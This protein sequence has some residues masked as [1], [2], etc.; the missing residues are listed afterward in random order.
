M[1]PPS[2][3]EGV[4]WWFNGN[5]V[6]TGMCSSSPSAFLHQDA[7]HSTIK[8]RLQ[9]YACIRLDLP[10]QICDKLP[11]EPTE[12]YLPLSV[13]G[14]LVGRYSLNFSVQGLLISIIMPLYIT[15]IYRAPP[16]LLRSV[17]GVGGWVG[18]TIVSTCPEHPKGWLKA[19][20]VILVLLN[21]NYCT[22][23]V[24]VH[25]WGWAWEVVI[26]VVVYTLIYTTLRGYT[27]IITS[28]ITSNSYILQAYYKKLEGKGSGWCS[29]QACCVDSSGEGQE[30]WAGD[31]S[32]GMMAWDHID[33]C[34]WPGEN[35]LQVP[36]RYWNINSTGKVNKSPAHKWNA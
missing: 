10:P 23:G 14:H 19:S 31:G 4:Y 27:S 36:M 20:L 33:G 35:F 32:D 3:C 16:T 26:K 25:P 11:D 30:G 1:A 17:D 15:P 2:R 29:M 12:N 6:N 9:L 8:Y 22:L 24:W 28:C 13:S 34:W 21:N 7:Q 18:Y 5:I